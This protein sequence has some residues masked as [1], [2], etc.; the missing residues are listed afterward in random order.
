[1]RVRARQLLIMMSMA[2]P[3]PNLLQVPFLW[4]FAAYNKLCDMLRGA[5]D[6]LRALSLG[7]SQAPEKVSEA[8]E[9]ADAKPSIAVGARI[10]LPRLVPDQ[11]DLEF[12]RSCHA[13]DCHKPICLQCSRCLVAR[14]CSQ[15]CANRDAPQHK[16]IC[17]PKVGDTP[18]LAS[19]CIG[20]VEGVEGER[21][22]VKLDSG[23][24]VIIGAKSI[25]S[26]DV[27]SD[28]APPVGAVVELQGLA[29]AAFNGR[30]GVVTT[31]PPDVAA[32]GRVVVVIDGRSIAIKRANVIFASDAVADASSDVWFREE[33]FVNI[34]SF[35]DGRTL[36]RFVLTS[37][38]ADVRRWAEAQV[39]RTV[40]VRAPALLATRH[41][42]MPLIQWWATT[43]EPQLAGDFEPRPLPL[44]RVGDCVVS[45]Y[46]FFAACPLESFFRSE[47]CLGRGV[48]EYA[49]LEAYVNRTGGPDD[50]DGARELYRTLREVLVESSSGMPA[51]DQPGDAMEVFLHL[52]AHFDKIL[53]RTPCDR[54]AT[55]ESSHYDADDARAVLGAVRRKVWWPRPDG[56]ISTAFVHY[57]RQVTKFDHHLNR[58]GRVRKDSDRVQQCGMLRLEARCGASLYDMIDAALTPE[59]FGGDSTGTR[60][61]T[62]WC[63]GRL[64]AINIILFELD[65]ATMTSRFNA[66]LSDNP[67]SFPVQ[68]LDMTRYVHRSALSEVFDLV[69]IVFYLNLG[70]RGGHYVA[71]TY[72]ELSRRWFLF[73][74]DTVERLDSPEAYIAEERAVP[75]ILYYRRR[76]A[77]ALL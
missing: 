68:G 61:G 59:Q 75:T 23:P 14:Y 26:R 43:V 22:V 66:E 13:P 16:H 18:A 4:A 36:A 6:A 12:S 53:Q 9:R 37:R 50:P 44:D 19:A 63:T 3:I 25:A 42:A 47:G 46:C 48:E 40:A 8:R 31:T 72:H 52:F 71:A 77:S 2:R 39:E 15:E 73:D 35:L 7:R 24:R 67:F 65:R 69:G 33:A 70:R 28:D 62:I 64:L 20:V 5:M 55:L 57:E 17:R 49:A 1:M 56:V 54:P 27:D 76:P 60:S 32:V 41:E 45:L 58:S 10:A 34:L 29:S 74:D 30:R 38:R 51:A 21:I 11:K